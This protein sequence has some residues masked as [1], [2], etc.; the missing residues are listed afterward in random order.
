MALI[1][2]RRFLS[3][4]KERTY[5]KGMCIVSSIGI[6]PCWTLWVADLVLSRTLTLL[7]NSP[8]CVISQDD[9]KRVSEEAECMSLATAAV[10]QFS[11]RKDGLS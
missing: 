7:N 6:T 2:K 9:E 1:S 8:Y 4:N 10:G 11:E 5:V 3:V